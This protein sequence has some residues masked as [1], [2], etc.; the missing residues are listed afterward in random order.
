MKTT[1]HKLL[2][3][4]GVLV[5]VLLGL[6]AATVVAVMARANASNTSDNVTP[7]V[8]ASASSTVTTKAKAR[9]VTGVIQ[10]INGQSIVVMPSKGKK[11]VTITLTATTK[12]KTSTG[13]AAISDLKVGETVQVNATND[14]QTGE[15][16]AIRITIQATSATPTAT[17]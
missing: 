5:I 11:P 4:I 10:S 7:T 6:S 9:R 3:I 1:N 13:K 2:I 15:L 16:D 14:A 8:T 12:Y 17:P